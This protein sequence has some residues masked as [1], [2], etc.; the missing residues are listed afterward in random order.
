MK[1]AL[2]IAIPMAY[3]VIVLIAYFQY[4]II[5]N[6]TLGIAA[7][8]VIPIVF[9]FS[10][11]VEFLRISILGV[12]LL[13]S[14]ETLAGIIGALV[15]PSSVISFDNIDRAMFGF[16]FTTV[17]QNFFASATMTLV[18]TIL[19]GSHIFL[20]MTA[21]ILFWFTNKKVFRGYVYAMILTSYMALI[22][23][24]IFPVAPP[25]FTGSANNLL[26]EG[27][28]MLPGPVNALQQLF[29]SMSNKV[30]AFP[31]LHAAYAMLFTVYTVKLKPKIGYISV[32]LLF[33]ILF[34]TIYLGQHYV[35]DLIAGI[36]YSLVAVFIVERLI[37]RKPKNAKEV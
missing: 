16:S 27:Y 21:M 20:V 3:L 18:S 4:G 36:V 26:D 35:I 8:I 22:T 29:L 33:G 25:W 2:F 11:S 5:P 1:N 15:S 34:S 6:I 31:S 9:Y 13:L 12:T 19:Y 7:I 30:A 23:F 14:Y 10:K 24:A 37:V 17:V 32:P 28:N